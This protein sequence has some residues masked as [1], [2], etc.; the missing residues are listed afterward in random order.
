MLVFVCPIA[1]LVIRQKEFV[2]DLEFLF[3]ILFKVSRILGEAMSTKETKG[4]Q[5]LRKL[6]LG[7]CW[8]S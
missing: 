2:K 6:N 1:F 4:K 5:S 3:Q 7:C 8:N